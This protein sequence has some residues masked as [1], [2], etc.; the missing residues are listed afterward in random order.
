M[1]HL[2][3]IPSIDFWFRQEFL[4]ARDKQMAAQIMADMANPPT[5][6]VH[7]IDGGDDVVCDNCN[8][9]IPDDG[10]LLN[11]VEFGRR[12][13]CDKCYQRWYASEDVTYRVLNPD[14]TLGHEVKKEDE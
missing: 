5:E 4:D 11:L 9:D 2:R 3:L 1:T 6:T 12:V 10:E 8:S 13:V 14:G 7:Y